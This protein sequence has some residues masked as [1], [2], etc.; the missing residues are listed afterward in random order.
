MNYD[1]I[2]RELEK[3]G[4]KVDES[5]HGG[6]KGFDISFNRKNSKVTGSITHEYK[7]GYTGGTSFHSNI[8]EE[9]NDRGRVLGTIQPNNQT[10]FFNIIKELKT[11]NTP[12][13]EVRNRKMIKQAENTIKK[14]T[15]QF[16]DVRFR[17]GE[18][19]L[20]LKGLKGEINRKDKNE[21]IRKLV[22]QRDKK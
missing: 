17:L 3:L 8:Y 13:R 2:I 5:R 12:F 9:V 11:S 14:L 10:E 6:S 7:G 19:K 16:K 21:A 20:W 22:I 1:Q 18:R 4:I 15:I